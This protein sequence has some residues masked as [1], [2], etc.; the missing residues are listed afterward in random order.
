MR[1][2]SSSD[3]SA[4]AANSAW[5]ARWGKQLEEIGPVRPRH[6]QREVEERLPVAAHFVQRAG[7]RR[8]RH[9]AHLFVLRVERR[10]VRALRVALVEHLA[11]AAHRIDDLE[12]P[13]AQG[14]VPTVVAQR[15]PGPRPSRATIAWLPSSSACSARWIG[16]PS[17]STQNAA[18][19]SRNR[20]LFWLTPTG[21]YMLTSSERI[22]T[23][24]TPARRSALVGRSP[25]RATRFGRMKL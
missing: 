18:N 5:R 16:R 13:V 25:V 21:S 23:Y 22:S 14:H 12:R 7:R 1:A 17:R 8:Q 6:P 19:A 24:C 10:R 2:C 3:S 4:S 20:S 9:V 11:H 15:E